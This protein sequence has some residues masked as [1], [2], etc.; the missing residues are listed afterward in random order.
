MGFKL[1]SSRGLQA[2]GGDIKS[3]LKF[4][5]TKNNISGTPIIRKELDANVMAEANMDGSIYVNK[6]LRSDD[7][8]LKQAILH[9]MQHITAMK[10]GTETYDDDAVYFHGETWKRDNGYIINPHTGE[11]LI[12]GDNSLPW[13]K[14]K[15]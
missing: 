13:E 7:P 15:I 12:E 1:G 9:E 10:L 11:R 2:R 4:G 5:K 6:N 14:N 8:M 3:K